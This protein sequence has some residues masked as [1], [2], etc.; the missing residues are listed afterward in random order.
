MCVCVRACVR[1]GVCSRLI[2]VEVR[3]SKFF[4][5]ISDFLKKILLCIYSFLSIYLSIYLYIY[6][7][8]CVYVH[9]C[10]SNFVEGERYQ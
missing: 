3:E 8:I 2:L 1:W 9:L 7:F 4:I 6:I 5:N 10:V